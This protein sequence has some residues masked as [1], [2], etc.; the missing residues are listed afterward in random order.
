MGTYNVFFGER[1][2]LGVSQ[3]T[4]R[5]CDMG[6]SHPETL[7]TMEEEDDDNDNVNTAAAAASGQPPATPNI[8]QRFVNGER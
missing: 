1:L 3:F 8:P 6:D 4:D 5:S 7:E 2:D